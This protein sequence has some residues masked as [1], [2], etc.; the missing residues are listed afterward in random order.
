MSE[1]IRC[2]EGNAKP[3]E[4][5]WRWRDGV[6]VET[7]KDTKNTNGDTG[8]VDQGEEPEL[9]LYGYI[10]E[11][12][13][14]EDDVTP[15]MFRDDLAKYGKGGPITIRMNSYGGDVIAASLIHTFIKDYPGHVTVQID[16]VAASAATVVAVAGDKVRMQETA[17]FMIHDPVAVF[18]LA[19]LNIDEL[20]RM[21]DSLKAVKEG[22]VNAYETKTGISRA[23]LGAMM[24][25]E[26]WFDA[27]EAEK[28]G[29]V[30]EVIKKD[31]GGRMKAAQ[32][33]GG[34]EHSAIVNALKNFRN[35]PAGLLD[36]RDEAEPLE[37]DQPV[38]AGISE[39][40]DKFRAEVKLLIKEQI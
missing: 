10:S 33:S 16:G 23:R 7:T 2:F 19:A 14:F 17:Y 27:G 3:H 15:K 38:D 4:A 29:F 28:L 21:A 31:E 32:D 8:F 12:S 1:P 30:D 40:M 25:K 39:A 5:F 11:Y 35:V 13:W 34:R 36:L 6:K 18:M 24:T 26:T 20:E 9:E 22:I 37:H